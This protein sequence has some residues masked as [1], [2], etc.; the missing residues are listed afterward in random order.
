[1]RLFRSLYLSPEGDPALVAPTRRVTS[2]DTFMARFGTPE[3]AVSAALQD[4]DAVQRTLD[5]TKNLLDE[6]KLKVPGAGKVV[7]EQK[8]ADELTAFRALKLDAKDITKAIAERDTLKGTVA[9]ADLAV[10]ARAGAGAA[11]LDPDGWSDHVARV[12]LVQEMRDVTTT[13]KG[14]S[15]TKKMP[16]VRPA[17]DDKAVFA[18][19]SEYVAKLPAHEQRAL[20]ATAA[21]TA[22]TL[23][24]AHA[25]QPTPTA[26][27]QTDPT[28]AYIARRNAPKPQPAAAVAS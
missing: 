11:G 13:E 24:L 26:S 16:F 22:P 18:P 21:P 6:T 5:T 3:A 15:V 9:A 4:L 1:M 7:L 20:A 19:A 17:N 27:Q 8:D 14:K 23:V 28:S 10:H 25:Q 12:G 2:M